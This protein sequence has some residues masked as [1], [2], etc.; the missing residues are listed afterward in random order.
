MYRNFVKFDLQK[1]IA[2]CHCIKIFY[3]KF[4]LNI[5]SQNKAFIVYMQKCMIQDDFHLLNVRY[6]P[7]SF[8]DLLLDFDL[9]FKIICFNKELN[10]Y[11]IFL[12]IV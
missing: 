3:Y 9:I 4:I 1:T 11:N 2:I 10:Y 8:F 6:L 7:C 5:F 12:S